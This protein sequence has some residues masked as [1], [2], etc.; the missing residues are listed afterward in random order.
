MACSKPASF[1]LAQSAE[2][3]DLTR[4]RV[5]LTEEKAREVNRVQK[6]LEEMKLKFGDV[7][8]EIMGTAS[9]MILQAIVDGETDPCRLAALAV[10]RVH[11]SQEQ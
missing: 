7:V 10:G 8:S 1:L 4:S 2:L 5:R 6:T 3:R 9:R 11:A